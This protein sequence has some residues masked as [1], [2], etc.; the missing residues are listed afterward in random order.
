MF[1]LNKILNLSKKKELVFDNDYL[2][3][4]LLRF[5]YLSNLIKGELVEIII[6]D[7]DIG[8]YYDKKLVLPKNINIFDLTNH[9]TQF[10]ISQFLLHHHYSNIIILVIIIIYPCVYRVGENGSCWS[11]Y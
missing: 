11:I 5:S 8:G 1:L 10:I 2:S 6:S 9:S 4:K 7:D 3:N